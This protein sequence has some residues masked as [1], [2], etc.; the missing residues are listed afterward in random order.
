MM[1]GEDSCVVV[2][3]EAMRFQ[4]LMGWEAGIDSIRHFLTKFLPNFHFVIGVS[5]SMRTRRVF[6]INETARGITP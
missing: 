6:I 3:K 2:T 4:N 1:V 5:L